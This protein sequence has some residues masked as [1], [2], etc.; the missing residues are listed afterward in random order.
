M[1]WYIALG[2]KIF[3]SIVLTFQVLFTFGSFE[4]SFECW[5]F[6]KR[7]AWVGVLFGCLSLILFSIT[8]PIACWIYNL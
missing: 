8:I 4:E 5:I 6:G 2:I 7:G 1:N 3:T